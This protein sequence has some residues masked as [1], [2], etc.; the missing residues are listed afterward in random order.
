MSLPP[1]RLTLFLLAVSAWMSTQAGAAEQ[2]QP[3]PK[4]AAEEAAG[5]NLLPTSPQEY[6]ARTVYFS[7]RRGSNWLKSM[8]RPDGLFVYGWIPSLNRPMEGNNYLRQAGTAVALAR[9]ACYTQDQSLSLAARQAILVLLTSYTAVD[10]ENENIRRPTLTPSQANPVGFVGLLLLAIS[11][12]PQPTDAMLDHADALARFLESR[13]REDGSLNIADTLILDDAPED[14]FAAISFY[15]GEALYALMRNHAVRPAQWKLD[16][17]AKSYP[18]Y[19]EHWKQHPDPAFIPWQSAAFAEA[20]IWTKEPQY[21]S[22]VLEMNDW[23]LQFQYTDATGTPTEWNGGFASLHGDQIVR[24]SPTVATGSYAEGLVEACRVARLIA[25][26][27][28]HQVEQAKSAGE[29]EKQTLEAAAQA[30]D[31]RL[32]LYRQAVERAF[33]FLM[34]NQY[35]INESNHFEHWFREKLNGAFHGGVTD[36]TVR[37]DYTQHVVCAMFHYLSHI[38]EFDPSK[39]A[40]AS[41]RAN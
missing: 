15:P 3:A 8:Q 40:T 16:V 13:Q 34:R 37:I 12:L 7:A 17:V 24:T 25:N 36:G 26:E 21:A 10:S 41:A 39:L 11:E 23:L 1:N 27:C 9:A 14:D 2:P 38:A 32:T 19:R 18:F 33:Q 31:N 30:A 22:F 35:S 28:K 29:K 4:A 20:Y 5:S 6:F